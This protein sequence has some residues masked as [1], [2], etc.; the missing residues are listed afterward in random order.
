MRT[1]MTLL[2]AAAALASCASKITTIYS[3]SAAPTV[4]ATYAGKTAELR[5]GNGERVQLPLIPSE[6]GERY[7]NGDVSWYTSGRDANLI[8]NGKTTRCDAL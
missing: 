2:I 8:R 1:T 4:A 7:S 3:C 5:F 6:V